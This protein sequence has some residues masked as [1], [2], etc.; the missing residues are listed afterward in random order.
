MAEEEGKHQGS[1]E[2]LPNCQQFSALAT[3]LCESGLPFDYSRVSLTVRLKV[4]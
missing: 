3:R 1:G 4:P 2:G